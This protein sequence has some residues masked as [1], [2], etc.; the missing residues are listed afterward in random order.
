[1]TDHDFDR[2]ARNLHDDIILLEDANA[3]VDELRRLRAKDARL[4]QGYVDMAN[5]AVRRQLGREYDR[6]KLVSLLADLI[7]RPLD[8]QKHAPFCPRN[9]WCR[10][11]V[12]RGPCDCRP[13][14]GGRSR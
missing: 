8:E 2:I 7:D 14:A 12:P 3:V 6:A 9:N 5:D 13:V 1:M 10:M 11:E 4:K